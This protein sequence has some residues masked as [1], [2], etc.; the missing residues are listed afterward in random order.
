MIC[1]HAWS[2]LFKTE[3]LWYLRNGFLTVI[4][5]H[6]GWSL[7]RSG[8]YDRVDC[9]RFSKKKFVLFLFN[10][11]QLYSKSRGN[12]KQSNWFGISL[13]AQTLAGS[14]HSPLSVA[15]CS[16]NWTSVIHRLSLSVLSLT[17]CSLQHSK[18]AIRTLLWSTVASSSVFLQPITMKSSA[19]TS[20]P[21]SPSISSCF[22]CWKTS[23][24]ELIP[25][26]RRH[27]Q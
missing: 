25:K 11:E 6:A 15:M 12:S 18:N 1:E 4:H 5:D 9:T 17:P 14:T 21:E 16:M 2:A 10:Q 7:T 8:R 20:M 26:D 3:L 13:I 19:T 22:F 27:Q 24:A 23:G